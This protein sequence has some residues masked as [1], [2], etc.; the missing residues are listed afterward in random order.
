[1]RVRIKTFDRRR[2]PGRPP[3]SIQTEWTNAELYLGTQWLYCRVDSFNLTTVYNQSSIVNLFV[4]SKRNGQHR[5]ERIKT[6]DTLK[7][8]SSR[9]VI[10]RYNDK[11]IDNIDNS[12]PG[13]FI[14]QLISLPSP[15]EPHTPLKILQS[16]TT[17]SAGD[18]DQLPVQ[19]IQYHGTSCL[20]LFVSSYVKFRYHH[21]FQG[22]S[23]NWMFAAAYDTSLPI[24]TLVIRRHLYFFFTFDIWYTENETTI[25]TC[26][27][28]HKWR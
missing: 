26:S 7:S 10:Q 5:E 23:E 4:S 25:T 22:T 14:E 8:H 13:C 20:E 15:Q 24:R 18:K 17:L 27:K 12:F 3:R 9:L 28:K 1:M 19:G 11:K 2:H 16:T 6:L 21:H